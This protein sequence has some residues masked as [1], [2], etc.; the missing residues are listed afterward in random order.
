MVGDGLVGAVERG[1]RVVAEQKPEARVVPGAALLVERPEAIEP[2]R[3]AHARAHAD[4]EGEDLG[5]KLA[6]LVHVAQE[7]PEVGD[8][9]G[10]GLRMLGVRLSA[11]QG[12]LEATPGDSFPVAEPLPEEPV[13]PPDDALTH[14]RPVV[15]PD[16]VIVVRGPGSERC[17]RPG[18]PSRNRPGSAWRKSTAISAS[19]TREPA[20]SVA[21]R[22]DT[23]SRKFARYWIQPR[24]TRSAGSRPGSTQP[25]STSASR[26]PTSSLAG[27]ARRPCGAVWFTCRITTGT[28]AL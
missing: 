18:E 13:E 21:R 23:G 27:A 20:A 14:G 17:E 25:S 7:R 1:Q 16:A 11:R 12:V 24:C 26:A 2:E 5:G 22:T 10:H 15:H 9:I 19:A 6:V 8:G 28:G 3:G 4:L